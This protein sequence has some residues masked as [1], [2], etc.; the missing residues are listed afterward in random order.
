MR[1]FWSALLTGALFFIGFDTWES[2]REARLAA[3]S[4]DRIGAQ[5]DTQAGP[6][7]AE[8]GTGIPPR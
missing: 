6:A 7:I 1:F 5:A 4:Q 3:Q 2:R 8:D